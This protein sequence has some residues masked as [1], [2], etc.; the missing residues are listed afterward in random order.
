MTARMIFFF[1]ILQCASSGWIPLGSYSEDN[2]QEWQ[3]SVAE[4]AAYASSS[5]SVFS[6]GG[7]TYNERTVFSRND[8][9]RFDGASSKWTL[10]EDITLSDL[11]PAPR[12]RACMVVRGNSSELFIFGGRLRT[13]N[14]LSEFSDVWSYTMQNKWTKRS[15]TTSFGAPPARGS[16]VCALRGDHL[17]IFGGS[18]ALGDVFSDLWSFDVV[19]NQWS[20][21]VL[22]SFQV[23]PSH[24]ASSMLV[25]VKSPYL[26]GAA[27][28]YN[29]IDDVWAI[30]GGRM[31]GVSGMTSNA[32]VSSSSYAIIFK[33]SGNGTIT[34]GQFYE[35]ST[36]GYSPG[37]AYAQGFSMGKNLCIFGGAS[38]ISISGEQ[39]TS[40]V[41]C[42][43]L[44]NVFNSSASEKSKWVELSDSAAGPYYPVPRER[45]FGGILTSFAP[46][47]ISR[48][49]SY[50]VVSGGLS[51]DLVLG[52]TWIVSLPNFTQAGAW[53]P[54]IAPIS[55]GGRIYSMV[56]G[57]F[58]L[59][60]VTL[61]VIL[62]AWK[63]RR[64]ALDNIDITQDHDQEAPRGL[65]PSLQSLLH[66]YTYSRSPK[67]VTADQ[68]R[69]VVE[70][71]NGSGGSSG[72]GSGSGGGGSPTSA[73]WRQ[74][75]SSFLQ[76]TTMPFG[77]APVSVVDSPR[78]DPS[79]YIMGDTSVIL[80]P[81]AFGPTLMS[82]TTSAH[83]TDC[84]ICLCEFESGD[85]ITEL[86]CHVDHKFHSHCVNKWL[87]ASTLCPLCKAD[88][89]LLIKGPGLRRSNTDSV[90]ITHNTAHPALNNS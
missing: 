75:G 18:N 56:V 28:T 66:I 4:G 45:S 59:I 80:P 46:N 84:S 73:P 5:N 50:L 72:G 8:L 31:P 39:R 24:F 88:V 60:L 61:T 32:I 29:Q 70:P 51:N 11:T 2:P 1:L 33:D 30:T 90:V 87:V 22:T 35:I 17:L 57:S 10:L 85:I 25:S 40:T 65:D 89:E 19:T 55:Q 13:S 54:A 78:L 53:P 47:N 7:F 81:T 42:L 71:Q 43:L 62:Y 83:V 26:F 74:T 41:Y 14:S 69:G 21:V 68:H 37:R 6:F 23:R 67:D 36:S 48:T 38:F 77:W 20:S 3:Q 16:S 34:E 49:H 15:S 27:A 44:E 52:D 86:P 64:D 9:W 79:G 76:Q 12:G 58:I 82:S 63:R